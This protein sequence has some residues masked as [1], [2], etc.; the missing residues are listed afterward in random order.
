MSR[1]KV[2][3]LLNLTAALRS[4]RRPLTRDEILQRV[5]GYPDDPESARRAFERD[6]DELRSMGVPIRVEGLAATSA[7]QVAYRIVPEE[8]V[9]A[10][11][12]LDAEELTALQLAANAVKLDGVGGLEAFWKLGVESPGPDAPVDPVAH[13]RTDPRLEPLFAGIAEHHPVT[14]R[15][16]D[17]DRTLEP[18]RID[19]RN[20]HWYVSGHD[21]GR[22][23]GRVFR[24]DRIDGDVR[25][26]RDRAFEP[27]V[28]PHPGLVDPP[29]RFGGDA[30]VTVDLVVDADRAAWAERH[31]GGDAVRA[32][33][34]EGT[35]FAVE[36]SNL[37]AFRSFV[38]MFL[39]RAEIVA[40]PAVRDDL[41]AWLRASLDGSWS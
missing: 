39:D 33:T 41:V 8:Y 38:L 25:V 31:F 4:T 21:V 32:R 28:A 7:E 20:G 10:D 30:A 23:E 22:G 6:K 24:V 26:E 37:A 12:G 15:Y 1:T 5:P 35:Q 19:F 36:V 14:F 18:H 29:W 2:E 11:P 17:V 13:L 34:P 40:P 9:L 16:G 3:R 27:P